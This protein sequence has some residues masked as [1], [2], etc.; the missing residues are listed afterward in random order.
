[1]EAV[2]NSGSQEISVGI[3]ANKTLPDCLPYR[4][5]SKTNRNKKDV[6]KRT[7]IN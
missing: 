4:S 1:M 6:Q 2:R 7:H 5:N 3:H